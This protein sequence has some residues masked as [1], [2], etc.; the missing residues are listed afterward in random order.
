MIETGQP[1][2]TDVNDPSQLPG[3]GIFPVTIDEQSQRVTTSLTY[4]NDEVR[5]RDNLEIRT[6]AEV[7]RIEID[8]GR[9]K[10]VALVSGEEIETDEVVGTA[11]TLWSP[12]M[13][14]R[15]GVGPQEHLASFE[16]SQD[17]LARIFFRPHRSQARS[18]HRPAIRSARGRAIQV[19]LALG[20]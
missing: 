20:R 19:S 17:R 7:A 11:G 2:A 16:R 18:R 1:T 14:L 12:T 15:S 8:D 5:E 4:L 10:G 3:I 9:A 6:H 13:L